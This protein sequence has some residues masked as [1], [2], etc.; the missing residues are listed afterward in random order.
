MSVIVELSLPSSTFQ[1]GQ[2]LATEGGTTITL[3]TMVPLGDRSVPFF[4]VHGSVRESFEASV[5]EH[6]TVSRIQTINTH[7]DETLYALDWE[8]TDDAFLSLVERLDGH[9]LEATGDASQWNF[10]LRFPTHDSLSMFQEHCHE[11]DLQLD[12]RRIYNPTTPE[13]GPWYGLT[14][15]Q[16]KTL[17]AAVERGYYSLPRQA[18]TQE[19]AET[20]DV[21]DQAI[22]ER[23]RRAI[24]MLVTNTLLL[25]ADD[26]DD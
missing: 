26:D 12:I 3:D 17:G 2:I 1:H 4:R 10:Q 18:S 14:T 7:G 6:P 16:R 15:P 23:L 24:E 13:A 5:R 21:S 19:L 9:V 25:T 20:F 11:A 8:H 22:T